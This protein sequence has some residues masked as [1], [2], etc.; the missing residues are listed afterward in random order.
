[1]R[2][3][4]FFS[5]LYHALFIGFI[6]APLLIVIAVSF[7]DK[8]YISLPTDGLSLRWFYAILDAT[9]IV[10]A[11]WMSLWLGLASAS[12]AVVL[13]VPGALALS[14]YRFPGRGAL[15]AFFMS[16]LMIP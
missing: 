3:N 10:N 4:G 16:P 11:F 9:D 7:T 6:T 2:K 5:L 15:M 8:G 13:A 12:V 14:R 1:M